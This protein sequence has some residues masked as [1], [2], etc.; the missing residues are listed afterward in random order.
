MVAMRKEMD[1]VMCREDFN[2]EERIALY[3]SAQQRCLKLRPTCTT[4]TTIIAAPPPPI[5]TLPSSPAPE[6]T[7]QKAVEKPMA[8]DRISLA[9]SSTSNPNPEVNA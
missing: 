1:E 2:P 5:P 7:A 6:P 4:D 8:Q 3:M 9:S